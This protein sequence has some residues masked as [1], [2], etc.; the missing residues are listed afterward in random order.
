MSY[1]Y[2]SQSC[3]IRILFWH[4]RWR[5]CFRNRNVASSQENG[6][7]TGSLGVLWN[8]KLLRCQGQKVQQSALISVSWVRLCPQERPKVRLGAAMWSIGKAFGGC[9]GQVL[10]KYNY[11]SLLFNTSRVNIKIAV[12]LNISSY[13][14]LVCK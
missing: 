8:L 5:H 14:E 1:I 13:T 12:G 3:P 11:F 6:S 9:F 4:S 10:M 2:W 7:A